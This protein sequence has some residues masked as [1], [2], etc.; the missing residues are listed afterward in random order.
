MITSERE[1]Y[2]GSQ[3]SNKTIGII[4][5]GR[6][7][8]QVAKACDALSM[9]VLVTDIKDQDSIGIKDYPYVKYIN[10]EELLSKSDVISINASY[11]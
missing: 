6:I 3:L 8:K 10:I 7:G 5:F 1:L 4:G 9:E 11:E 2:L